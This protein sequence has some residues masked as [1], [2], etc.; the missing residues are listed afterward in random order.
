MIAKIVLIAVLPVLA[1]PAWSGQTTQHVVSSA[2]GVE[3]AYEVHGSGEPALVFVHGW[4]C[5]RAYWKNQIDRFSKNH[6]VVALDLAGHGQSGRNRESWTISAFGEDVAAVVR[7]LGFRKVILVGHS[8]GGDVILETAKSLATETVGLAG[9]DT[10]HDVEEVKTPE[11]IQ[12]TLMPFR[13]NFREATEALVRNMFPEDADP[14]L[15]EEIVSGM[16]STPQDVGVKSLQGVYESYPTAEKLK[17]LKLPMFTINTD[18]WVP[19][20]VEGAER[21]G[22]HVIML[23]GV[24]HFPQLEVPTR[25]NDSLSQVLADI[26]A[27]THK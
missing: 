4:G 9:V 17:D 5:D 22:M 7:E 3:I 24:G 21:V 19:T 10:F 12:N 15:V 1:L 26:A 18:G 6:A 8:M 11:Q 2:D 25:F 23:N 13:E 16:I 14:A 27:T 20:N